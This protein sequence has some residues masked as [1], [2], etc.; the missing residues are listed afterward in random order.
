M[1][2]L[3]LHS[4][5]APAQQLDQRMVGE[6]PITVGRDASADWVIADPGRALSR[7]HCTVR[8][9]D[10][11]IGVRDTSANGTFVGDNGERIASGTETLVAPGSSIRL[12]TF[13]LSVEALADD[14]QPAKAPKVASHVSLFDPPAGLRP[15]Q[16]ASR[17]ARPDPF[18]SQLPPD[19]LLADHRPTDRVTLG[20]GDA[21]DNRPAARAGDWQLPRERPGHEQLIG[22]PRE[23]VEPAR[24]ERDAGFGFDVPFDRPILAPAPAT[25]ER[26]AIPEDWAEPVVVPAEEKAAKPKRVA[27]AKRSVAA[28]LAAPVETEVPDEPV[29]E[30]EVPEPVIAA[31]PPAPP[32][33][34]ESVRTPPEPAKASRVEPLAAPVKAA[35]SDVVI[36][37]LFE[38]FCAGA[39]L[40]PSSFPEAERLEAM[41]RLGEVYRGMVLG[42]ADLMGERTTLKNE[43][44]M[45]RTMVRPEQNNPFKWVPPQRLAIEVLRGADIGFSGGAEAVTEGF[46]DIKTHIFCVLAGMRAAIATTMT[47][48]SPAGIEAAVERRSFLIKAQRD[49]AMWVQY[50]ERFDRLK[51]DGEDADGVINR[52]FR[53]AYEKQLVELSAEAAGYDG[54]PQGHR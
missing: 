2:R 5:N 37:D 14:A 27:A 46:R 43:Y 8:A 44:R 18:A 49:A 19:P 17:P 10:G 50:V 7:R 11:K 13:T 48:L 31:M 20:D 24:A 34:V 39:R 3:R 36:D 16:E 28:P 12:G 25:P 26:V 35:P 23:W 22:T 29:G 30:L 21:W 53:N 54:P 15:V 42:L 32:L 41:T 52:A 51:I 47:T 6:D 1:I 40:S 33:P 9:V 38:A 4:S 45:S